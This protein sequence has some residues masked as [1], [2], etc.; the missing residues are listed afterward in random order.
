MITIAKNVYLHH[1]LPQTTHIMLIANPLYD[2]VFKYLMED[3]D[4]ARELLSLIL[5]TEIISLSVKPQEITMEYTTSDKTT[6]N[7]YRLDFVAVFKQPNG[8]TKKALIELQKSKRTTDIMRFRRYLGENYQREDVVTENGLEVPKPLEI[9]TIY[10]LGFILDDVP[11]AIMQVKNKFVNAVT[12]EAL[13]YEPRDQFVR[14]LNH[15][16]YTIQIPL[17]TPNTKNKVELTLDIF[18][19]RYKTAD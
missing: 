16:S 4:I 11:V 1:Y 8:K 7:I 3:L 9:I 17:L 5:N 6:I 14:L 2:T 13:L 15:E 19:Q 18:N 12:G 10:L